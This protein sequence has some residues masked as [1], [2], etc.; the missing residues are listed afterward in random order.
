M[1]YVDKNNTPTLGGDSK[2]DRAIW[3]LIAAGIALVAGGAVYKFVSTPSEKAGGTSET[4]DIYCP[5][6]PCI[7][8]MVGGKQKCVYQNNPSQLCP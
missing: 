8:I 2:K 4:T 3:L 6:P 7:I 1:I 5:A